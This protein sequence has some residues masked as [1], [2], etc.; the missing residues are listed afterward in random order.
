VPDGATVKLNCGGTLPLYWGS[1]LT[2]EKVMIS[3]AVLKAAFAMPSVTLEE[4]G[5]PSIR[6]EKLAASVEAGWPPGKAGC[7]KANR[8]DS[9]RRVIVRM[10][11]V[12]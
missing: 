8:Q 12:F 2:S 4:T 9:K 1:M 7:R 11:K 3:L 10:A 6:Q 5:V